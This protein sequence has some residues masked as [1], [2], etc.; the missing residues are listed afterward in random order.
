M[1]RV[2]PLKMAPTY[3]RHHRHTANLME[4]MRSST[5]KSRRSSTSPA[6][7]WTTAVSAV[8]RTLSWGRDRL[9]S[10]NSLQHDKH[11]LIERMPAMMWTTK[12]QAVSRSLAQAIVKLLIRQGNDMSKSRDFFFDFL[13]NIILFRGSLHT[14]S[15]AQFNESVI[16][17]SNILYTTYIDNKQT[18]SQY[19]T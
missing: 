10:R 19:L 1:T 12:V 18:Q 17:D 4:S 6:L 9:K 7:M 14:R 8:S 15:I 5:R 3:V 13:V 11:H 16:Q 2:I